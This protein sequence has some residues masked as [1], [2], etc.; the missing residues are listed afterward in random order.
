MPVVTLITSWILA[1]APVNFKQLGNVSFIVIGVIIASIGEIKFDL[2]GFLWQAGG[3]SFEA[4]RLVLVQRLLS[5]AEF[6]MD[7]LTS[8]VREHFLL[9]RSSTNWR[10]SIT[11][12]L[13]AL[14]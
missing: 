8:L 5:S 9:G 2:T 6:K 14:S 1:V 3:I 11:L 10:N 4:T 13:S 7:P 12:L